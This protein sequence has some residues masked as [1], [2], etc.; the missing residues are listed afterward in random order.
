MT[1]IRKSH[2]LLLFI[3]IT[4][5]LFLPVNTFSDQK[6][7]SWRDI[8]VGKTT[9]EEIIASNPDGHVRL[10]VK[11]LLEITKGHVVPR[12]LI[13]GA[14]RSYAEQ[15]RQKEKFYARAKERGELESIKSIIP[16]SPPVEYFLK[17]PLLNSGPID[18]RWDKLA[19]ATLEIHSNGTVQQWVMSYSFINP[20]DIDSVRQGMIDSPNKE[21]ILKIFEVELG[22]PEKILKQDEY[23]FCYS[24]LYLV[25]SRKLELNLTL[26]PSSDK[27]WIVTF[28]EKIP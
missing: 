13:F 10:P 19:S 2:I 25:G 11:D 28:M 16:V 4:L 15:I 12:V 1:A 5:A 27:V 21:E 8:V 23:D 18:L 24:Y 26:I 3:V 22:K 14:E 6:I 17:P 20:S 7:T 9:E